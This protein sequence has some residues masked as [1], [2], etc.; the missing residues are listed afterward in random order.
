MSKKLTRRDFMQTTALAAATGLTSQLLPIHRALANTG[1]A[2]LRL[3]IVNKYF[4]WTARD[5]F[6]DEI[7]TLNP[8]S[9]YGFDLPF[10]M[11]SFNSLKKYLTIVEN[12]R[13]TNWGN[14]HD[15]SFANILTNACVEGEGSSEQLPFNEPMGPS[16]DWYVANQLNKKV[17]RFEVGAQYSICFDD[18]YIAQRPIGRMDEFHSTVI[19]PILQFQNGLS[20]TDL[21]IRALNNE[22][23]NLVNQDTTE[24][25][26][27]FKG[28][29][30]ESKKLENFKAA[31]NTSNPV[32][33]AVKSVLQPI[34]DPGL[35]D[36][37]AARDQQILHAL[38]IMKCGFMADTHRVGV[39]QIYGAPPLD[40][41]V[42]T[43]ENGIERQNM[44]HINDMWMAAGNSSNA[45]NFHHLVSHYKWTKSRNPLLC[46]RGANKYF[47]D[48]L[49][50]FTQDL[51]STIDVDGRPMIENTVILLTG[52]IADSAHDRKRH[53][54]ILIGGTASPLISGGKIVKG[55][56]VEGEQSGI[57][58]IT[59]SGDRVPSSFTGRGTGLV[60]LRT[61]GD[62]FVTLSRAM[63]VPI[64]HFGF[65]TNN[66]TP[67]DLS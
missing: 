36:A 31:L 11:A 34:V 61:Q 53:P 8:S 32:N 39:L 44:T 43:D 50:K 56:L 7:A 20:E 26:R 28:V 24:L 23:F 59:R 18:K 65:E 60:S 46:M 66:S 27:L 40:E 55:P 64:N 1:Q 4:G 30:N 12:M 37:G 5:N 58:T 22:I 13:G 57:E 47:Y 21:Q 3:L 15:T 38:K 16:I 51:E 9:S 33:E 6:L 42:W 25:Q 19:K 54:I 14:A 67:F 45:N 41:L 17:A 63:G 62:L 35:Q 2:P 29:E 49:A 52:E 48:L 10:E